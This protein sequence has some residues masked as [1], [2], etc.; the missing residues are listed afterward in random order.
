M[1]RTFRRRRSVAGVGMLMRLSRLLPAAAIAGLAAALVAVG[2]VWGGSAQAQTRLTVGGAGPLY[3]PTIIKQLPLG[4]FYFF[5]MDEASGPPLS[6]LEGYDLLN[7]MIGENWYPGSTAQ[8]V[9]YPASMGLLSASFTAPVVDAAVEM[10]R[11]ALD[12][13]IKG[14]TADGEPAVVA[15]LSEGT[16]VINREL[17]NLATDPKAPPADKLSF[18]MF[19]NPETG[20]FNIYLPTGAHLPVVDYTSQDLPESQYDL[21]VV[22]HQYDAWADPPDRPW[23]PAAVVNTLFGL[24]YFHD[25]TSVAATSDV[26]EISSVTSTLGGTT[27]TYMIPSPTLP[28]LIPLR[29]IGVPTPIVDAL[30]SALKPVVDAGYSRLTPD[31]GPYFSHGMLVG[32]PALRS[33]AAVTARSPRPIAKSPAAK[34]TPGARKASRPPNGTGRPAPATARKGAHSAA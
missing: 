27:T 19:A 4:R 12:T 28:M 15:A 9:E 30:N 22:F 20:L 23:N 24:A 29:Q 34:Q 32:S 14:E 1:L 17:A 3:Y 6:V 18:A 25:D 10:G 31:A 7:H 13:Q 5:G 2:S 21:S 33:S 26:V 16:L 8:V 11:A